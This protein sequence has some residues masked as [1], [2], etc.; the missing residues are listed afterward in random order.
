[1]TI[2]FIEASADD[3]KGFRLGFKPSVFVN[4]VTFKVTGYKLGSYEVTADDGTKSA[5]K[6]ADKAQNIIFTTDV[7]EDLP[8]N[9]LLHKRKV[10]YDRDNKAVVVASCDFQQDL[11]RHLESLGRRPNDDAMLVGSAKA[12][13]EHALAFFK[14]KSIYSHEH[15]LLVRDKNNK[16]VAPLSPIIVMSFEAHR[17]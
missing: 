17:A 7:G 2:K 14:D 9:R 1:M 3:G 16:L 4:G 11:L 5:S 6:Y 15:D 12:V 13:A 10:C 8:L